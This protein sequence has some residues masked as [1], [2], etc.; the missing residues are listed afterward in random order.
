M[1]AMSWYPSR[2]SYFA[3]IHDD[4][5]IVQGDIFWGVP[6]LIAQHPDISDRFNPPLTPLPAAEDVDLPSPSRVSSG[7]SVRTDPVMVL[8]HTCDFYG[9]EKGRKNRARLVARIQRVDEAGITQIRQLRSG[10]GYNHTFY[11]PSWR[12][13]ARD[14]DDMFVNFRFMTSVDAAY[15]NRR[16]REARL[17]GSAVIAL[18]R[19]IAHFFTDY[20]PAP[21]ELLLADE[22]GGLIRQDRDLSPL[23]GTPEPTIDG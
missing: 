9:P 22:R 4:D 13:P 2:D 1:A 23:G 5:E 18:R 16:Y 21:V 12:D 10:N 11:L 8:P 20:A 15:L 6:T 14:A 7:V 3:P 17:S 19:R